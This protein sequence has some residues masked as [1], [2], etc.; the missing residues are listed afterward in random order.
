MGPWIET[1]LDP[2][3][4]AVRC[5]VDGELRQDGRTSDLIFGLKELLA[6]ISSVMTLEP[7]DL[8][9]TGTPSGV[10]PLHA[11]QHVVVEVE[12]IGQLENPVVG[13]RGS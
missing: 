8:I 3:N 1:D 10:G 11:G 4:L 6:F 2:G 7:G 13:S 9:S 5:W 12:G